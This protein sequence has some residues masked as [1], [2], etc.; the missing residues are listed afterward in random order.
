[1]ISS[2]HFGVRAMTAHPDQGGSD[3]AMAEF[4]RARETALQEIG[5]A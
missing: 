1:M 5:I 2:A 4:N 3:D